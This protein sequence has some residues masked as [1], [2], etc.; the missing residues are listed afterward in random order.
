MG[1]YEGELNSRIT[2]K[3]ILSLLMESI[4]EE[5]ADV[6]EKKRKK[7]ISLGMGDPTAH[8]CFHTTD[9]AQQAVV[10]TLQ[11]D[12]FNGYSPTVGLP[13]TRRLRIPQLCPSLFPCMLLDFHRI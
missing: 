8:T 13:Q 6:D 10:E 7:V 9:V 11:S 5:A 12:K 4:E 2:I 1:N 3:G